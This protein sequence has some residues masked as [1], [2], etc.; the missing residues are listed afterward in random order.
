V[1]ESPAAAP[2]LPPKARHPWIILCGVVELLMG[3]FCALLSALM[4]FAVLFADRLP[5]SGKAPPSR[6]AMVAALLMFGL[7][8]LFF[9]TVGI[10]TMLRRRW[11]RL[12]ML[13]VSPLWLALGVLVSIVFVM[14]MPMVLEAVRK[15]Q[16]AASGRA[17]G[18]FLGIMAG[19]NLFLYILLPGGFLFFYSRKSV[20]AAFHETA[21]GPPRRAGRPLPVLIL[22][23][24]MAICAVTTL[25]SLVFGSQVI[26]GQVL[27]GFPAALL[28]VLA[29]GIY[30]WLARGLYR[31]RKAAWLG[32]VV[33][34][35]V[36]AVSAFVTQLRVPLPKLLEL[37][38]QELPPGVTIQAIQGWFWVILAMQGVFLGFVLF[39]GRYFRSSGEPESPPA[40]GAA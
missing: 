5:T 36:L 27:R 3:A 11:A 33:I 13:V 29:A 32:S 31:M 10:G 15:Q 17:M 7:G 25:F 34:T 9:V 39:V 35:L 6:P 26:F 24:W 12:V 16:E 8:A 21:P 2:P 38:H 14:I 1:E 30:A 40:V 19:I 18:A 22:S 23:V 37:V 20:K 28:T 4:M